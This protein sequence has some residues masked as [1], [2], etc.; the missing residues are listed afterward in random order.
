MVFADFFSQRQCAKHIAQGGDAAK[1]YGAL[2]VAQTLKRQPERKI[3]P[4]GHAVAEPLPGGFEPRPN[5][6]WQ[7]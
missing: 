7:C 6:T 2:P 1:D 3:N 4:V 5:W